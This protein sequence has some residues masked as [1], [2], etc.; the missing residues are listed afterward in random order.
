MP[1]GSQIDG[2]LLDGGFALR[3]IRSRR[4][5]SLWYWGAI[6]ILLAITVS[7]TP[8]TNAQIAT[9]TA[10]LSGVVS[11]PTGAVLP[12]A[13]VTLV[14]AERGVSRTFV[15]DDGGRYTFNQ[16]PPGGYTLTIKT[17]G[18]EAYQQSGIVLNAG[19]TATQN[20]SLTVGAET[21][22]VDVTAD[23][24]L[25][26]TDN[27]N[28]ATNID[29]KQIVELPLNVRNIYGLATLNSSVQNTSEGQLLLGGGSNT[30]DTADQ[31]I[32]FMNF[33]GGFF[34]TTAFLVDGSWGTDT[35][36]GAVI[37]V[38]DVDAVQEFKIQNNS[39]TA[40]YGWST[41]NV[42]NVVTKSGTHDFHGSAYEFYSSNGANALNYFQSPGTCVVLNTNVCTFSRNQT[43][44]T[45][46][47]P[48]YIPGLYRQRNKTFIFGLYEHFI[49][50]SPSPTSFTVPDSK[51]LT[52]DFSEQLAT[53]SSGNDALGR[54]I[55][56]GQVYDPRS[57][58]AVTAGMADT[59]NA[60]SNPYGTGLVATTTG[61]VRNPI[62]GNILANLPGYTPD[63]VGAKLLSYYPA[64]QKSGDVG[65]NLILAG[66]APTNW[67]EY[68]IRVDQNFN[69]N[70][71]GYFRYSYKEESKT[72]NAATWGSDPAGPGNNRPNNRWGM[73]SQG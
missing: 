5:T 10:T 53:T 54:P 14:S 62:P 38:P 13:S 46:G 30:T 18:F 73:W 47:G 57:G 58:H 40:Q 22:S 19:E 4:Q 20:V 70:T 64:A 17:K 16:L 12:K 60:V 9:T 42:V 41:G 39:F 68:G 32:S 69:P 72:G 1:L 33:G 3:T 7:S 65:N 59:Y 8:R 26:N 71:T 25:L 44:A 48:L 27:S 66:K 2:E 67:D 56:I 24:S 51:F 45:A 55:Y 31:D 34:G 35:E 52:G 36:W 15:S 63:A 21:Q 28:V 49:S 29:A 43:G 50:N 61:F 6:A 23:A 37:F 11:D